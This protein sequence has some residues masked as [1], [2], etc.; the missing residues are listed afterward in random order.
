MNGAFSPS[1]ILCWGTTSV[2]GSRRSPRAVPAAP[3]PVP[4]AAEDALP[5]RASQFLTLRKC[6]GRIMLETVMSKLMPSLHH[7]AVWSMDSYWFVHWKGPPARCQSCT[8]IIP[9]RSRVYESTCIL[10]SVQVFQWTLTVGSILLAVMGVCFVGKH[11]VWMLF[12]AAHLCSQGLA[13]L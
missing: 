11:V 7:T 13:S 2:S 8:T 5:L 3:L 6:T 10:R 1:Q 9:F 12:P 4:R